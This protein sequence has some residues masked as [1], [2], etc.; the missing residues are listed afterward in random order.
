MKSS[1]LNICEL[2]TEVANA[3]KIVSMAEFEQRL[4]QIVAGDLD[5]TSTA[6]SPLP[7]FEFSTR[8]MK[9]L[10]DRSDK[11]TYKWIGD[12][13]QLSRVS[14]GLYFKT[15]TAI[16]YDVLIDIAQGFDINAHVVFTAFEACA[17]HAEK[18]EAG[19][20]KPKYKSLKK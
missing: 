8:R 5:L 18:L 6:I 12:P 14:H 9:A 1:P 20:L 19:L 3:R 7:P 16:G 2:F 13:M 17:D 11:Q 10:T 15:G 4:N